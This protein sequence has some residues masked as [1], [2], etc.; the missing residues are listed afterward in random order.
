MIYEGSDQLS[1]FSLWQ[2]KR[3]VEDKGQRHKQDTKYTFTL[4]NIALETVSEHMYL[5]K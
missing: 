5:G 2:T 1:V 3:M 4:D